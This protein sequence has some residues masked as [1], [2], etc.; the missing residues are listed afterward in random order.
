MTRRDVWAIGLGQCVNWGVLYYAFG[1]LLVPIERDLDFA[2]WIVVGAFSA[3]LLVSALA[4]P[5]VGA[6]VDRGHGPAVLQAGGLLAAALLAAWALSSNLW[7]WYGLW[8]A[9]GFCMSAVLYEPV[10]AIVGQAIGDAGDRLR[11]IATITVF[12]GVASTIFLPLTATLVTRFGW[13]NAVLLLAVGLAITTLAVHRF[14]FN[15]AIGRPAF[16]PSAT[17]G[18]Q[19][20]PSRKESP[21]PQESPSRQE[22]PS[23][24]ESPSR[25]ELRS[26]Q[27]LPSRPEVPSL[28][29]SVFVCT[30]L[31]GAALSTNLVPALIERNISPT[32][33]AVFGGLFGVM[34]LPGRLLFMNSR[35]TVRPMA[36]LRSSLALQIAG[37]LVLAGSSAYLAVPV[38]VA[39]FAAGSG[40]ATLA[41]PYLVSV[42]YGADRAGEMNGMFARWQQLARAGGPV[43]AAAFAGLTGYGVVFGVLA[44]MLSA[45]TVFLL[46][47]SATGE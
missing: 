24:Q 3:A 11:A 18:K 6:L 35:R 29:L 17:A 47:S 23:R 12:G 10:F 37:L 44:A 14:T 7:L 8:I 46:T 36:I 43:S 26:R 21:S 13:R 19:E 15:R 20:L 22:L 5:T 33:A 45:V 32:T 41:R 39:L 27:E 9:I 42:F 1:V 38:G 25:Q 4:A 31:A 40:L 16:A 30:S 34:Q 2:R 28:L